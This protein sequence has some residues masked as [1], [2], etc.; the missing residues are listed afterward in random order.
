VRALIIEQDET[1]KPAAVGRVLEA[2][3]FELVPMVIQKDHRVAEA[4]PVFPDP[5]D[6]DL[7]VPL[8]SPWSVYDRRAASWIDPELTFL[9]SAFEL[10]VPVFGICFGAQALAAALG[11]EVRLAD[12]IEVGW[13]EVES[14]I[15][16]IAGR[17]FQWHQDVFTVPPKGVRLGSSTVGPQS[18]RAGKTMAVQFH[19]EVDHD[20]LSMWMASGGATELEAMGGDVE[21]LL[22]ET[23][24]RDG[25][26]SHRVAALIDWF[27]GEVA[28]FRP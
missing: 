25:E 21:A 4:H 11:G 24:R 5:R 15:E 13:C 3:G 18:F 20:H 2:R 23:K 9:R 6:F 14:D 10:D 8:G 27:L 12:R 28:R 16:A 19:P 22:V 1:E 7:V 26:M 17:W